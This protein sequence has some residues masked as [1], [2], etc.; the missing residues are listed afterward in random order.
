MVILVRIPS[1]SALASASASASHFL[2]SAISCEPVVG[3]LPSFH[4]YTLRKHA[5]SNILKI[6]KSKKG[7][8]SDEKF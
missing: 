4:G 6:L 7:N 3:L 5:Y 8:F 1:A 2:V